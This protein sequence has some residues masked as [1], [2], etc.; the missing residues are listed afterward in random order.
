MYLLKSERL[1]QDIVL[2]KSTNI[3]QNFSWDLISLLGGGA[4]PPPP[5]AGR[6]GGNT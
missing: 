6:G 3:K 1:Y 2:K 4:P 5:G